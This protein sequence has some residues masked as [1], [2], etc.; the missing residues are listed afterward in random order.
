MMAAALQSDTTWLR[1]ADYE[2]A[3][4]NS[5]LT[6]RVLE[7]KRALQS[8]LSAYPDTN[9]ESFYDVE[10]PNGWAYIHV[11]EDKQ[12]GVSHRVFPLPSYYRRSTSASVSWHRLRS[13]IAP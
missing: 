1:I 8:G 10:L 3:A 9:R 2:I 7:L 6:G 5:K 12:T 13:T 4:L 11:R